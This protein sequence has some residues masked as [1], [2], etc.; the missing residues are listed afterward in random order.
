MT[1][2]VIFVFLNTWTDMESLLL[3]FWSSNFLIFFLPLYQE[4]TV[5]PP[6]LINWCMLEVF[7]YWSPWMIKQL[8]CLPFLHFSEIWG[9]MYEGEKATKCLSFVKFKNYSSNEVFLLY[10]SKSQGLRHERG[11]NALFQS[12]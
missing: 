12:V 11:F 4:K 1:I 3:N 5:L 7:E 10:N 2:W 8:F 9:Y 6:V